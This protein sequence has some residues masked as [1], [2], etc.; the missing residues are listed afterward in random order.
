METTKTTRNAKATTMDERGIQRRL[1]REA[2]QAHREMLAARAD[3]NRA[4]KSYQRR[5]ADLSQTANEALAA[6]DRRIAALKAKRDS[7]R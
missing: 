1:D 7:L 6:V 2:R 3:L 4:E 5:I